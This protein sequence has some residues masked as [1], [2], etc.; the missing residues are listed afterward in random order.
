LKSKKN[1]P[2]L[3]KNIFLHEQLSKENEGKD[4]K[5]QEILQNFTARNRELESL[6]FQHENTLITQ[7][8]LSL[9]IETKD[10]KILE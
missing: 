9:E 7:Q 2:R 10:Q 8:Q 1:K 5:I 6:K 4:R 3:Q